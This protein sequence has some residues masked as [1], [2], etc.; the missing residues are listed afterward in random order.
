MAIDLPQDYHPSEDEPYM[1]PKQLEYFKRKLLVWREQLLWESIETKGRLKEQSLRKPDI[2]DS[3]SLE[4]KMILELRTHD[5]SRKLLAK[6]KDALDRIEEGTYGYCEE[7]GE[8]IGIKRLE[9]RPVATLSITAQ[10]RHEEMER[11]SRTRRGM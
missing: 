9:A 7:T 5:R 4:T 10:K 6:I 8:E 11:R 3:G 2:V 1:N